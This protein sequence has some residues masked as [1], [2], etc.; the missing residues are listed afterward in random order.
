MPLRARVRRPQWAAADRCTET[1]TRK[2]PQIGND[3]P[4][5]IAHAISGGLPADPNGVYL[6][7]TAPDVK[8]AGFCNSFC[9]YHTTLDGDLQRLAYPLR[10]DPGPDATVHGL[11]RR[12]SLFTVIR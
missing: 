8:I 9:A 1:I 10:I 3:I 4:K 5:I 11:Q 7:I 6:V 2:A 12:L